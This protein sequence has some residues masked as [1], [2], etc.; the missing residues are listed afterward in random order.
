MKRL[1]KSLEPKKIRFYM[2]GEYGTDQDPTTTRTIGRPHYHAIIFGHDFADK[3]V[4]ADRQ[5]TVYTSQTLDKLW[6]KGFTTVGDCTF[7]SAAY[8]ARYIM[9]KINGDEADDHYQITDPVT[10]EITNLMPEFTQQSRRPGIAKEWFEKY[11]TDL[12][13]GF[14]TMRGIKMIPPKYYL[15][16]YEEEYE[17]DYEPL[18]E[19]RRVSIDELDPEYCTDRLRVKE[20][21]KRKRI[22]RLERS[23]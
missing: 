9:K 19:K 17:E 3:Q 23:L 11:R 20:T 2:C 4:F 22:K 10:G 18:K 16:L 5:N 8:V 13:K 21:I 12:D 1:R 6:G 14:L 15:K 7:E